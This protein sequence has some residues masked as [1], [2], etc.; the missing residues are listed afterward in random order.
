MSEFEKQKD[1]IKLFLKTE[2]SKCEL[3][4]LALEAKIKEHKAHKS[5]AEA[6]YCEADSAA[7]LASFEEWLKKPL[8]AKKPCVDSLEIRL[9]RF[10]SDVVS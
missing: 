4:I 3:D 5:E 9:L 7:D 6:L 8:R 10:I 2:A 1:A